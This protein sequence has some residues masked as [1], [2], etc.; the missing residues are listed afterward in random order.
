MLFSAGAT[1]GGEGDGGS[2][3]SGLFGALIVEP[4]NAVWYRSQVTRADL[5]LATTGTDAIR[6]AHPQLCGPLSRPAIRGPAS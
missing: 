2:T 4:V 3:N 6:P 1:N 5:A